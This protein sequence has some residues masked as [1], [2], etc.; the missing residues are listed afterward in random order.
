MGHHA[1][2]FL[3]GDAVRF[4]DYTLMACKAHKCHQYFG[5]RPLD[6]DAE[7]G[8]G[9]NSVGYGVQMDGVSLLARV[10]AH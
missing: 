10:S 2:S 3:R 6:M 5:S 4:G 9:K 8:M 7:S 1:R